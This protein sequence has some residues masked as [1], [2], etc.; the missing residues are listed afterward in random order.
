MPTS[1]SVNE[2]DTNNYIDINDVYMAIN[3]SGSYSS[4]A[5]EATK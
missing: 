5:F 1:M 3:R 2:A 4:W